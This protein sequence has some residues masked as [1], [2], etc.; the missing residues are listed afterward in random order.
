[1]VVWES[2]LICQDKRLD[3]ISVTMTLR[4]S[5]ACVILSSLPIVFSYMYPGCFIILMAE[6]Q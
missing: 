5:G 6:T 4:Y 3:Q 1:M 2:P